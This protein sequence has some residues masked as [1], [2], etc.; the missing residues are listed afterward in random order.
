MNYLQKFFV[1]SLRILEYQG[2]AAV[3]QCYCTTRC[4]SIERLEEDCS[5]GQLQTDP[6]GICL[7]CAPGVSW[8]REHKQ[9]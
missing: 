3:L 9:E 2:H 8:E 7:Q 1:D 4:P 6:C 5:S